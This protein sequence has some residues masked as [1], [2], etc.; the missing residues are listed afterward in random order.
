M[1]LVHTRR[2]MDVRIHFAVLRR[3]DGNYFSLKMHKYPILTEYYRNLYVAQLSVRP[4]LST[5]STGHAIE[6][7]N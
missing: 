4:I 3:K 7:S 2:S 5:R 1:L 6:I